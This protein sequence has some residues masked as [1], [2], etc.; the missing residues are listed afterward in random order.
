M[1][2]E[3][4][5]TGCGNQIGH[6]FFGCAEWKASLSAEEKEQ[7]DYSNKTDKA[8]CGCG[9]ERGG[10]SKSKVSKYVRKREKYKY[11]VGGRVRYNTR[12][13]MRSRKAQSPGHFPRVDEGKMQVSYFSPQYLWEIYPDCIP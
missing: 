4:K 9:Y 6:S 13:D 8:R 3:D 10:M 2:K 5:A 11:C 12:K 1:E 7:C